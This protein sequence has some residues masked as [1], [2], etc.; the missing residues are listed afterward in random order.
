MKEY[1][2]T[3]DADCELEQKEFKATID[4]CADTVAYF[5]GK[6]LRNDYYGYKEQAN[7]KQ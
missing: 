2:R 7:E 6:S 4:D 1:E 5:I 3:Y